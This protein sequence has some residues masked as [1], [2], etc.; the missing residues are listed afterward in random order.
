[1]GSLR[2]TNEDKEFLNLG[3][4]SLLSFFFNL[5]KRN[6]YTLLMKNEEL[7]NASRTIKMMNIFRQAYISISLK[8]TLI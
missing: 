8:I 4:S 1:M 2:E 3:M 6:T 5:L 7:Q